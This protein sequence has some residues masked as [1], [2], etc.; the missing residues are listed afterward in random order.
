MKH[1]KT[2]RS[3]VFMITHKADGKKYMTVSSIFFALE[4]E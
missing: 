1:E 4:I 2:D 3:K